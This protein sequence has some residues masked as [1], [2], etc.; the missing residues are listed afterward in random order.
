[1]DYRKQ[2]IRVARETLSIT[3]QGFYLK[4]DWRIDLAGENFGEAVVILPE[5]AEEFETQLPQSSE[6]SFAEISVT[7]E[8]S[9]AAA[10]RLGGNCLVMN[11]ANARHR[12]GGF[13]NGAN[14]QEEALCRESTLYSSLKSNAAAEMYDYNNRHRNPCMYNAMIL[15]PNVCVFRD[16]KDEFLDEHFT[17]AVITV[18]ALNKNGEAKNIPQSIVDEVMA[19]RLR[20]MFSAAAHFGYKNLILG[21]WGCGAFG[22]EPKTVA[23][24]FYGLLISEEFAT[25]FD[26]IVFAILDKG[27]QRNFKAFQEIFDVDFASMSEVDMFIKQ[28]VGHLESAISRFD[29]PETVIFHRLADSSL[30]E[31][32]QAVRANDGY[33]QDAGFTDTS[34]LHI[35]VPSKD[36]IELKIIVPAGIGRG[37]WLAPMSEFPEECQFTLNRG[38]IYKVL[39]IERNEYGIWQIII[40]AI[41]RKPEELF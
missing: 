35:D 27:E 26:K 1:M 28:Q 11:F 14:A 24:Y 18:P 41:G 16:I 21:A 20:N 25:Y 32:F 5:N 36:F 23:G 15:S 4:G 3:E 33:F 39:E 19:S 2:N 40:V 31:F 13:L 12:G 6:G 38:T 10:R 7:G 17:T 34:A 9:F 29:L 22:H 30:M 37:A 8:D